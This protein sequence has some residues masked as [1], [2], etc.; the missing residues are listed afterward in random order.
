MTD[1]LRILR[2][3]MHDAHE[4]I[5]GAKSAIPFAEWLKETAGDCQHTMQ[6][7]AIELL[8]LEGYCLLCELIDL[9]K[10]VADVLDNCPYFFMALG[11]KNLLTDEQMAWRTK[12]EKASLQARIAI[13]GAKGGD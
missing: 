2:L 9:R 6:D 12:V 5:G 7:G 4:G 10:V 1:R 8:E 13:R 11:A 3:E